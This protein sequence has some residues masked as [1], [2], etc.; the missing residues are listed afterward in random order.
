MAA[1][2]ARNQGFRM[3]KDPIEI[4][5]AAINAAFVKYTREDDLHWSNNW[6]RPEE[7]AH[8][9]NVIMLELNANGLQIVNKNS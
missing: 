5:K 1:G 2:A 8:L 6:I 7:C 9:T 3:T 4:I